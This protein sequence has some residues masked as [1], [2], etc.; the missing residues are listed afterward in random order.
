MRR[1]GGRPGLVGT[2]ARTAVVAGTATAVS[3][4][5]AARQA[6]RAQQPAGATALPEQ[7]DAVAQQAAVDPAVAQRVAGGA[8]A[9]AASG[10]DLL[11]Q[12]ERLARLREQG[13]LD[14]SEFQAA[15]A[16]LLAG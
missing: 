8:P 2:M 12:L 5:V 16:R 7:R 1:R 9:A 13:V 15:K 6:A 4:N 3:G 10:P 14:E 11:D